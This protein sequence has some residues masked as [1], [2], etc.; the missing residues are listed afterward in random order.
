MN[1]HEELEKTGIL[2]VQKII[3]AAAKSTSESDTL[4]KIEE[5]KIEKSPNNKNTSTKKNTKNKNTKTK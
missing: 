1:Y 2:E 3:T 4:N 5:T